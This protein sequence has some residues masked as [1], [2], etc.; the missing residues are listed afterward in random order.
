MHARCK[1]PSLQYSKS[2]ILRYSRLSAEKSHS[3]VVTVKTRALG[4]KHIL[5][6]SDEIFQVEPSQGWR[7]AKIAHA[8]CKDR[9]SKL[10]F[11]PNLVQNR[12][13]KIPFKR[14]AYLTSV[15]DPVRSAEVKL[16]I[17]PRGVNSKLGQFC[18]LLAAG[19]GVVSVC[20]CAWVG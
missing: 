18:H 14:T 19:G 4:Q 20:E 7:H 1:A 2:M 3:V 5:L 17:L 8:V 9:R 16:V 6:K 15:K 11:F 10:W 13:Q 12:T